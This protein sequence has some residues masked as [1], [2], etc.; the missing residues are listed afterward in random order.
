LQRVSWGPEP[1]SN[2]DTFIY[3]SRSR[4]TR[5]ERIIDGRLFTLETLTFDSLN[6]PLTVRYPDG[7][8]VTLTYDGEGEDTLQVTGLGTL[9]DGI[10]YNARGQMT[11]LSRPAPH[12]DTIFTYYS[13]TD[14]P[15][16]LG[17]GDSNFRLK[18][19]QTGSLLNLTYSYDLVGNIMYL[20]DDVKGDMQAF[21]Y[22]HLN[23]LKTAEGVIVPPFSGCS[24]LGCYNHTYNYNKDGVTLNYNYPTNPTS[25]I[26]A[27]TSITNGNPTPTATVSFT[28]DANG[29]MTNRTEG[30]VDYDQFFDMENRLTHVV[31]NGVTTRFDYDASGQRVKTTH[32]D[33]SVV[34]YPFANYEVEIRSEGAPPPPSP[35]ATTAPPTPTN[36]PA[37]TNTPSP[38][39]TPTPSPTPIT[40]NR[41]EQ[42]IWRNNQGWTRMVPVVNGQ[43]DWNNASAWSG[44]TG[45][46]T[47]PGSG[48]VE[49]LAGYVVG[50]TL[51]QALWRG[52]Q[53]WS[54][55][56]PIVNGAVNWGGASTWSGPVSASTLPGSGTVQSL[57][58]YKLGNTLY[59]SMWR[60]DQGWTREVPIVSNQP[61]WNNASVW[62]GPV[63]ISNLPGSGSVNSQA[64]FIIGNTLWQAVWRGNQ[65]WARTV[66]I[67]GGLVIWNDAS[68]WS[69]PTNISTLP[70]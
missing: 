33:G 15:N 17:E 50:N 6:R 2:F 14:D 63:N 40:G 29:N 41:V 66:P 23:R 53:G 70:G 16:Q 65:G 5:Q 61:D 21:T 28:Y 55:T 46:G 44:S 26:H 58:G 10:N 64:D 52:N 48:N 7:Q 57:G 49:V 22:D 12:D 1:T 20:R 39:N 62:S 8:D 42:A 9:V 45:T 11:T 19:I 59:Q 27:V 51:H 30:V 18:G 43:P 68:N 31:R 56:V 38:T 36:T 25:Q 54:R 35:T 32:P 34:Y 60:G 37:P 4:L 69:G 67:E 47:L 3:D 24:S 13:A